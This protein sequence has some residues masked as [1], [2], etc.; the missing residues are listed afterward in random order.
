[1]GCA[2]RES[3]PDI[4]LALRLRFQRQDT[5]TLGSAGGYLFGEGGHTGQRVLIIRSNSRLACSSNTASLGVGTS[6]SASS[7]HLSKTALHFESSL[8]CTRLL[9]VRAMIS[10]GIAAK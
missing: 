7:F 5:L 8:Q 6:L 10:K 3:N 4:H 9:I 2:G 1:L